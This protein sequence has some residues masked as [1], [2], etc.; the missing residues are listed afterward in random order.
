MRE[1]RV[2]Q[3][4]RADGNG[5]A[6]WRGRTDNHGGDSVRHKRSKRVDETARARDPRRPRSII[7][8]D[9]GTGPPT[10]SD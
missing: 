1:R 4:E 2:A 9:R 3:R 6:M 5:A 7:N 10:A 8:D